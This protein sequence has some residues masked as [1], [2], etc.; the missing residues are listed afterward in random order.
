[1]HVIR[2]GRKVERI[3]VGFRCL[4][5]VDRGSERAER[6]CGGLRFTTPSST[7][8]NLHNHVPD[9]LLLMLKLFYSALES[10]Y[11]WKKMRPRSRSSRSRLPAGLD[12]QDCLFAV[13]RAARGFGATQR[14]L[15]RMRGYG[16]D[17]GVV[18]R[19]QTLRGGMGRWVVCW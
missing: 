2:K 12:A 11:R 14:I 16:D 4:K 6:E 10:D 1:M 9:A 15:P 8:R 19:P 3:K 13:D 7:Q 18:D 17:R 5:V